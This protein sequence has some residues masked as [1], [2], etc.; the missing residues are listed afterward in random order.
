MPWRVHASY[1]GQ[2]SVATEDF[3]TLEEAARYLAQWEPLPGKKPMAGCEKYII[4][5]V[6]THGRFRTIESDPDYVDDVASV[7][8]CE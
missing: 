3:K 1:E 5:S 8:R 7:T 2:S 6:T 4:D